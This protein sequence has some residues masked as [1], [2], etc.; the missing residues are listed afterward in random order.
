RRLARVASNP[1]SHVARPG[2]R[3][4]GADAMNGD[5]RQPPRLA[6]WLLRRVLPPDARGASILGDLFEEFRAEGDA[7]HRGR[8]ARR[9]WRDAL[10]IGARYLFSRSAAALAA[11][12]DLP[13]PR[14]APMGFGLLHEDVRYGFRA[15]LR[16]PTFTLIAL[17]TLAL[18][19]GAS[20]AI[21]SLAYTVLLRPLPYASPERLVQLSETFSPPHRR[22][23]RAWVKFRR[24]QGRPPPPRRDRAAA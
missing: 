9:Y 1:A 12:D 5:V 23:G 13:T 15:L 22:P 7:N 6:R 8:A 19:I 2:R 4:E 14:S 11:R 18:G 21:F 17:T 24:L 16:T 3:A 20:T 10:S